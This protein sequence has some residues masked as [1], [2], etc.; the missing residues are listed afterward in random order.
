VNDTVTLPPIFGCF[1]RDA[2]IAQR[3]FRL[4]AISQGAESASV[5]TFDR[6]TQCVPDDPAPFRRGAAQPAFRDRVSNA[7]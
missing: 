5:G 7:G 1:G 6:G 2:R 4:A 3:H